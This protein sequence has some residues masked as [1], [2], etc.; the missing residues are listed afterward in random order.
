MNEVD[1]LNLD[2]GPPLKELAFTNLSLRSDCCWLGPDP[3]QVTGCW[4][5][6][7]ISH[8]NTLVFLTEILSPRFHLYS[9]L[10]RILKALS[11]NQEFNNWTGVCHCELTLFWHHLNASLVILQ[12]K[13]DQCYVMGPTF[14]NIWLTAI[15]GVRIL[16]SH[17]CRPAGPR[18]R[19]SRVS[20][21]Q[22]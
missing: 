6:Q 22:Y 18:Y 16:P 11:W 2:P 1:G 15:Y 12:S 9:P 13:S 21:P 4:L 19:W 3:G 5:S 20:L 10:A 14:G 17:L 7:T 8:L